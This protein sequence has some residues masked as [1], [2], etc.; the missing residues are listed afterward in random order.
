MGLN[1][2]PRVPDLRARSIIENGVS[3]T[4]MP[5][6][7]N[8]QRESSGAIWNLGVFIRSL[9]P[10]TRIEFSQQARAHIIERA[11]REASLRLAICRRSKP[12]A[13]PV[14]TCHA[15]KSTAWAE[16][17]MSHWPECRHGRFDRCVQTEEDP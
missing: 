15:E 9:R 10:L 12:K 4:G 3:L 11:V 7:R 2:Y 5:T 6:W 17:A 14:P 8:A 16:E 1:L 13:F